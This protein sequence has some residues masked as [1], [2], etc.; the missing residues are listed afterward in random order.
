MSWAFAITIWAFIPASR[1]RTLSSLLAFR[2]GS[3]V[4]V[5]NRR[6]L[7]SAIFLCA[8]FLSPAFAGE[9]LN[10]TIPKADSEPKLKILSIDANTL[11]FGTFLVIEQIE[12]KIETAVTKVPWPLDA[13]GK[14]V[15]G[16]V[17]VAITMRMDGTVVDIEPVGSGSINDAALIQAASNIIHVA[18]PFAH[19]PRDHFPSIDAIRLMRTFEFHR[20]KKQ[21]LN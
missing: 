12:K 4:F 3:E 2:P 6:R 7:A 13:S 20:D 14:R 8:A 11:G 21:V 15:S 18:A 5:K 19:I 16:V 17:K 10:L 1:A 9:P